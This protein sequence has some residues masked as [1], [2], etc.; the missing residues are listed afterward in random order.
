MNDIINFSA[1]DYVSLTIDED[2][3]ISS[4]EID[5]EDNSIVY[6][7]NNNNVV[8]KNK[9]NKVMVCRGGIDDN[10]ISENSTFSSKK[11]S[12]LMKDNNI[13]IETDNFLLKTDDI[14]VNKVKINNPIL[15]KYEDTITP[16]IANK[17]GNKILINNGSSLGT[18]Y[19]KSIIIK[20]KT[21]LLKVRVSIDDLLDRTKLCILAYE[22]DSNVWS[23]IDI[24][25]FTKKGNYET[26]IDV[27]AL[28]LKYDLDLARNYCVALTVESNSSMTI[29]NFQ[30]FENLVEEENTSLLDSLSNIKYEI[31]QKSNIIETVVNGNA[32][33]RSDSNCIVNEYGNRFALQMCGTSLV[34]IPIIPKNVLYIGNN[35]L[36]GPNGYGEGGSET[37]DYYSLV[38]NYI[39]SQS[40]NTVVTDRMTFDYTTD[41]LTKIIERISPE[42]ELVIV[43]L[44]DDYTNS[45]LN[46]F[47][48]KM[49]EILKC[50]RINAKKS[51][52]AFVGTWIYS[53]EKTNA[54]KMA[55]KET[56]SVFVDITGLS[57]KKD[58][59]NK[60]TGMPN[61][62]G[63]KCIADKI[64][65]IVL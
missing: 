52:V 33:A 29:S 20:D 53:D 61:L 4:D 14:D 17:V 47:Y 3:Y 44:G 60:V 13:I 38:N 49:K 39:V 12:D 21:N 57:N 30:V 65:D 48:L 2:E 50:I 59:K 1:D 62:N 6:V 41:S 9:V 15:H 45:D 40:S 26:D 64:I 18:L 46:P 25:T 7:D 19:L 32:S 42:V 56:G 54:I 36:I 8:S 34:A 63:H 55:C 23:Q 16:S 10:K 27:N 51:R 28:A 58:N 31:S 5:E 11:I 35:L 22:E 37:A 43:Q 24:K